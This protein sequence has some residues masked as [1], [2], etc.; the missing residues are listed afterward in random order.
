MPFHIFFCENKSNPSDLSTKPVFSL[1]PLKEQSYGGRG[2]IFFKKHTIKGALSDLR[3]FLAIGSP[4]KMV[5]NGFYFTS[6]ALLVL[7]I[8]RFLS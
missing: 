5:K 8:F 1:D 7:K 4:L 3:Q 6:K 2:L